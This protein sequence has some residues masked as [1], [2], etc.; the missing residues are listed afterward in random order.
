[1][2]VA[3]RR[4]QTRIARTPD[5]AHR[6]MEARRD[7]ATG[8]IQGSGGRVVSNP[9]PQRSKVEAQHRLPIASPT[10]P[11]LEAMLPRLRAIWASGELT[12]GKTV[13]ELEAAVA[14]TMPG[15]NVVAVNSCTSGLML[16]LRALD[17]QGEVL[18]PSFTFTASA[19][20]VVWAG[21]TPVFVDCNADTL[22]IDLEDLQRKITPR[23]TAILA[24]YV[25]GNPPA[26]D[27][28]EGIAR[29]NGLRLIL[30]AAHAL[31]STY[32]GRP[33]GTFGD[34]EV[35]SLS[36]TKT[37]TTCEGGIVSLRD[38]EV[39]RRVKIGRNYAN[40][41]NYD[42]QFVGLNARMS[43]LHALVGVESFKMLHANVAARQQ[44]VKAYAQQLAKV[45]G[46]HLQEVLSGNTSS[47]KDISLRIVAKEFGRTRDEVRA[48]L[49]RAGI[50]TRTYFDPP[51]H[52]QT[53]Y[54]PWRSAFVGKLPVTE[55]VATEV[56]NLP[57]FVGLRAEDVT[58][59]VSVVAACAR[60]TVGVV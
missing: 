48:E 58:H 43:E 40:P 13:A 42:C 46:V 38:P 56:L 21:C 60:R 44:L 29:K 4:H 2:R 45:R 9:K 1:M 39:A 12:N 30:D 16:A 10:L 59:V 51:V 8:A 54:K 3:L 34:A 28:L 50:E 17:V 7:R 15:R 55:Q 47:Q 20:A 19:H 27:A 53:A 57:L 6:R 37:I 5:V 52:L 31:G 18:L 22:N 25:S 41:G 26:L 24:V 36:P 23:T 35:F 33:A 32:Q 14:S 11:D 49:T